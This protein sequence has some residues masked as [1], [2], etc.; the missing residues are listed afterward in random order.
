MIRGWKYPPPPPKKK[1]NQGEGEGT[2]LKDR[3]LAALVFEHARIMLCSTA[4]S[5]WQH[6]CKVYSAC[7]TATRCTCSTIVVGQGLFTVPD[8]QKTLQYTWWHAWLT[9]SRVCVSVCVWTNLMPSK[10]ELWSA[11]FT[12][13]LCVK[14][15]CANWEGMRGL[16]DYPFY[17]YWNTLCLPT[18]KCIP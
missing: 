13:R 17:L 15:D 1:K 4:T 3:I 12:F 6:V 2:P 14:L 9:V 5:C 18:R 8:G 11:C 7:V 16:Q 10:R